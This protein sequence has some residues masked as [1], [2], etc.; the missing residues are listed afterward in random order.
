MPDKLGDGVA[1]NVRRPIYSCVIL[2]EG[3]QRHIQGN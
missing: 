1:D 3:V 2:Q